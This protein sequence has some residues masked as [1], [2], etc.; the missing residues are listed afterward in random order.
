MTT[1]SNF[2]LS[3]SFI[4]RGGQQVQIKKYETWRL[5]HMGHGTWKQLRH[6]LNICKKVCLFE[7]H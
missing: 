6:F 1:N 7:V 5:K 4:L 3:A 2:P